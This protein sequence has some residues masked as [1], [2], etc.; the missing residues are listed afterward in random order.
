M[1][2]LTQKT[3]ELHLDAEGK[4]LTKSALKKLQKE[5][6]KAAKKAAIAARVAAEEQQRKNNE[7]DVSEGKYGT[8]PLIQSKASDKT[9]VDRVKDISQ[10][11]Q[12]WAGKD[13]VFRARVHNTR[14]QGNKMAFIELRQAPKADIIQGLVVAD[15]K[16]IS[17]QFVKWAGSLNLESIVLVKGSVSAAPEPIKSATVKDVEIQIKELWLIS[18]TPPQ[19]PILIEDAMRSEA[20]AEAQNL[21]VVNLDTRLDSRVIDLRTPTNQAIFRIQ[22]GVCELFREFLSKRGFTEIHTPKL[23]GAAS[24]GGAN[25]FKVGYFNRDAYLAQSPQFYKQMLIAADY[26][27]V[28]EVGPIFRAENSNTHR[29]MTEFMGLDLEMAFEEHYDEVMCVLEEMF[30][31]IFTELKNRYSKEIA[32]VRKQFPVDEFKLP[33]DGKMPRINYLDGMKMLRENGYPDIGDYEDINTEQEKALG[34]LV[35]DKYDTDFYILDK[36]PL[37]V[38]PFYTMPDAENPNLSNSYDFFM[39]GEEI[40]SGAQRIHDPAL[41]SERMKSHGVDPN[42][43]GL[44]EYVDAFKYGAAPHAGGGIGLERVVMFFLGLGNI[45]RASLFP[46]DP[47][48]IKP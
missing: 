22:S 4:P 43:D 7:P 11:D 15:G 23:L 2:D 3:E 6:E 48:R 38:R 29:H 33:A 18:G 44:K 25:V 9:G 14:L 17:K 19:L 28:F 24:E 16:T 40:M 35:H 27:K 37:A 32:T 12:S 36:F 5:K 45:R 10:I 26:E 46:R 34:K 30:V 42:G 41:L 8:F 21:P 20:E 13:I 31:F 39:R 1:S 47:K